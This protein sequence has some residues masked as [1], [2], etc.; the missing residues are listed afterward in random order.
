MSTSEIGRKMHVASETARAAR[1]TTSRLDATARGLTRSADEIG[2]VVALIG[3]IAAQTNL[4][5]LNATI[6]AARAGDAGKGFGVVANEVKDLAAQTAKATTGIAAQVAAMRGVT[7]EVVA[8]LQDVAA[9]VV[10]IDDI[11]GQIDQSVQQQHDA[12]AEIARG[13]AQAADGTRRAADNFAGLSQSATDT[14]TGANDVLDVATRFATES[15]ALRQKL[16][17]F[18]SAMRAA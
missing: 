15:E 5:A 16:A 1:S 12:T 10:A 13:A 7:A 14:G 17:E 2:T 6:E 3:D 9:A 8:A 11:A 18:V 4:L